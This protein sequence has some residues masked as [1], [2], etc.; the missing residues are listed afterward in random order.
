[1]NHV[2]QNE[3]I[4]GLILVW[5]INANYLSKIK[6]SVMR[7]VRPTMFSI[8]I[9]SSHTIYL[10]HVRYLKTLKSKKNTELKKNSIE[11]LHC[12]KYYPHL[13]EYYQW[14]RKKEKKPKR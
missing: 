1:M 3:K 10:T 6:Q 4:N 9:M 2:M 5:I 8:S 7:M 13:T 14:N 12:S 11:F